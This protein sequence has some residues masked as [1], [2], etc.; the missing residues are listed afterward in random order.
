MCP[1]DGGRPVYL[2]DLLV[3]FWVIALVFGKVENHAD[4]PG[5]RIFSPQ[6]GREK[7]AQGERYSDLDDWRSE[8]PTAVTWP[9]L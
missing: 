5:T 7:G 1:E 2:Q 6:R 8:R 3:S 4:G 9:T